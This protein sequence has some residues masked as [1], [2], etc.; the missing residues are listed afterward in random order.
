MPHRHSLLWKL[1][2]VLAVFCL[3]VVSLQ[4]DLSQRLYHASAHLPAPTRQILQ[5][6]A[7]QAEIAW[8]ERGAAG[9]DEFL[10]DL[11][12]REQVWAVVV[13]ER[14]ASLS[15]VAL[16]DAQRLRLDFVRDISGWLGRPGGQP[17]L[18][19]PFSDNTSRL[20][21]ELPLHLDPRKHLGL[22]NMLLQQVLPALLA[23]LFGALLYRVLISPLVI[24]RRQANALSAGD[25]ASRVGPGVTRRRDELGEL[26][27]AFDHM[28][29]RLE[30]TVVLQRRLLRDLSHELRTPLSR[31]RVAG[32]REPDASALRQRLE[33]EV[34]GMER[35][36][37]DALE[38]V[39]LDTER[40]AMPV[41]AVDM[42]SLWD[43]LREDACF[44]SGWPSERLPCH[45]P[46]DC[47]VLGNLNGLAQ[48]LENILRNAIRHSPPEGVVRLS[49]SRDGDYW[50][51][52]IED[53]GPGIKPDQ[54]QQ[55]FLPF[56]RLNVARPGGDG[57]GLGLSITR[58]IVQLQ[59]GE[60]WAEN[61][62][63]GLRL[64]LRLK[65]YKL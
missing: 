1:T 4:V 53:Q 35:L 30:S 65:V 15:S 32:E 5:E 24:L 45:L 42:E 29:E 9:V 23:L 26:A 57:Y 12:E 6:Y 41:E 64:N 3:L 14:H 59:G 47:C 58:S 20:V 2:G 10:R 56:T 33:R 60:I 51:L 36:I 21:M 18:Y 43:L 17:T 50:H 7:R 46:P 52:R 37:G 22:W 49:G 11:R 34:Q 38:L 8:R 25:L 63:P 39:W 62:F 27:R 54:L 55:I 44:E 40:P 61:T 31:L 16:S 13:N 48:A 19:V 28:A